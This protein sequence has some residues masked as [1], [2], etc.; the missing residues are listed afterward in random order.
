MDISM[1][2]VRLRSILWLGPW[3]DIGYV[4]HGRHQNMSIHCIFG[5]GI[6]SNS[7][8]LSGKWCFGLVNSIDISNTPYNI[9]WHYK[10][11][12]NGN[13]SYFIVH[14]FIDPF[15]VTLIIFHKI[16]MQQ[17]EIPVDTGSIE[18]NYHKYFMTCFACMWHAY[19]LLTDDHCEKVPKFRIECHRSRYDT[20][21][22][23]EWPMW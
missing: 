22:S 15:D 14:E 13:L 6:D 1:Y 8:W 7:N 16:R 17:R 18:S 19:Q 9:K 10:L 12:K 2:I 3:M 5:I 11:I 21:S 23:G 20:R 4:D